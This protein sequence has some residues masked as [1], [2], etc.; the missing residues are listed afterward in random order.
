M[1]QL[2]QFLKNIGV[3]SYEKLTEEEKITYRE[4]EST[5]NGRQITD[6]EVRQFL[7]VELELATAKLITKKLGDREDTFLKM[8]VEFIRHLNQFLDA[9]KRE[10]EQVEQLIKTNH[11]TD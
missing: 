4:W 5:L 3:D 7:D 6:K 11:G 10:Q 1:N 9:P 2:S 8:K